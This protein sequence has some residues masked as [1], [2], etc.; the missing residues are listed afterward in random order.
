MPSAW[1]SCPAFPQWWPVTWLGQPEKLFDYKIVSWQH[2]GIKQEQALSA[3]I[4]MATSGDG[5]HGYLVSCR[6]ILMMLGME[7][8]VLSTL[9]GFSNMELHPQLLYFERR[10]QS[11]AQ[12]DL[13]LVVPLLHPDEC[14]DYRFG[15]LCQA[16]TSLMIALYSA[17]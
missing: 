15:P 6:H 4:L 3:Y 1:N 14:Q 12:A 10:F 7:S 17:L 2:E 16:F 8:R 9:S 13:E 11:P 5:Y